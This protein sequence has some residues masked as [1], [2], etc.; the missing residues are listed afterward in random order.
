MI[1]AATIPYQSSTMSRLGERRA[2]RHLAKDQSGEQEPEHEIESAEPDQS[3]QRAPR[4][5]EWAR[6]VLRTQESVDDPRLAAELG[7]HPARRVR[8]VGKR[9]CEHQRPE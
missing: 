6:R 1:V 9:K 2:A 8:D 4:M 7:R 3:E 5:D